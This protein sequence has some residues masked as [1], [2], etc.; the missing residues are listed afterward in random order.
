MKIEL[1]LTAPQLAY[2][3]MR[4]DAFC[5]QNKRRFPVLDRRSKAAFTIAQDVADKLHSKVRILNRGTPKKS[6]KIT[7]KYHEAHS[8][9]Y[10]VMS[11]KD[12][13]SDNY[14]RTLAQNIFLELD[15]KL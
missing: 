13:N 14:I 3:G 9:Q 4:F 15:P 10:F 5:E 7:F 6:Y 12:N 11:D 1:K 8:V 2:L